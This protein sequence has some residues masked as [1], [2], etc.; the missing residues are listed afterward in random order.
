KGS[1][2]G[3]LY[4]AFGDFLKQRCQGSA[5]YI[6]FGNRDLLRYIGLKPTWKRAL[7]SGGLDGRLAKF[8]IY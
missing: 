1:D 7:Q 8:E 5:A 2:L 3:D 4:K 6:Y